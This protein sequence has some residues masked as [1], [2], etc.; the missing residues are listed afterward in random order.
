MQSNTYEGKLRLL[1]WNVAGAKYLSLKSGEDDPSLEEYKTREGFRKKLNK[2]LTEKINETHPHVITLQE[3]VKYSDDGN[4]DNAECVIDLPKGYIICPVWLIDTKHYSSPIKWNK[5]IKAGG[6]NSSA[7]FAQGNATLVREDVPC[8]P[9]F[10]LPKINASS[11]DEI[12]RMESVKLTAGF[13][14]GDRNTEPRAALITHLVL[15]KFRRKRCDPVEYLDKPLDIFIINIHLTTIK[16]EREGVPSVDQEAS[17]IRMRQLDIVTNEIVSRYNA[18]AKGGYSGTSR[19]ESETKKRHKPIWILAGDF[20]FTPESYEYRSLVSRGF[21]DLI[22][23]HKIGTK[24]S[25]LG[26]TP[27][28]TVDYIFAGPKYEALNPDYVQ[29]GITTNRVI[30]DDEVD[31]SDHLPIIAAVPIILPKEEN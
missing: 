19:K 10:Q 8:F 20:N 4:E 31:I 23:D 21:I 6:W 12:D 29:K 2:A 16:L 28:L 26:E 7:Y 22:T 3:V 9:V 1:N 14:F 15:S 11:T 24:A 30:F 27:T 25:G 18:W 5:V 17:E 13:Y